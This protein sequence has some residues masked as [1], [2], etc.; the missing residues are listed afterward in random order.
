MV[1]G[2]GDG[3]LAS[4]N[5]QRIRSILTSRQQAANVPSQAELFGRPF[6]EGKDVRDGAH[7]LQYVA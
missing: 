2:Q 7:A 4:L 5:H 1:A 6:R 3:V